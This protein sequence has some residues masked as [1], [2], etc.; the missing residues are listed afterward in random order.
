MSFVGSDWRHVEANQYT[1]KGVFT[2]LGVSHE[3]EIPV[4]YMG[5]MEDMEGK[6]RVGFHTQFSIKRSDY[7]MTTD[8]NLV[9]DTVDITIA[10]EAIRQDGA[11]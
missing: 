4:Y 10:L 1:L 9:G 3:I 6:Q 7:G 8:L 2:L 5:V 11:E